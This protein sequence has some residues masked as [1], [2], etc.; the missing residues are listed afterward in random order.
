MV[1]TRPSNLYPPNWNKLRFALFEK[2]NY[3]CQLCGRYSK[4]HL[5]LHHKKPVKLGGSHSESNLVVLCS[6]C[7]YQ[8][9]HDR[10][11]KRYI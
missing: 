1:Y 5:H 9:H 2:Y 6:D 4:G 10:K 7:H 11:Y 8:I 3:T